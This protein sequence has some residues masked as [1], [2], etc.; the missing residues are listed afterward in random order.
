MAEG[1]RSMVV[2]AYSGGAANGRGIVTDA[3]KA[4]AGQNAVWGFAASSALDLSL[5]RLLVPGSGCGRHAVQGGSQHVSRSRE[6]PRPAGRLL[7][8]SRA[9]ITT[10]HPVSGRSVSRFPAYESGSNF[11]DRACKRSGT[12]ARPSGAHSLAVPCHRPPWLRARAGSVSADHRVGL[13]AGAAAP[14]AGGHP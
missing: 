6:L 14:N 4:M 10:L 7:S 5:R 1:R 9:G 12:I 13:A 2:S 3:C 11:D 8:G